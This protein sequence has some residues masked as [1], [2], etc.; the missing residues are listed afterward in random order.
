MQVSMGHKQSTVMTTVPGNV[1][2][3][4]LNL[5]NTVTVT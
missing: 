1:A 2:N 3:C 4:N 5:V